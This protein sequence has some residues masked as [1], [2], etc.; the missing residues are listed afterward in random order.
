MLFCVFGCL[1]RH[2]IKQI[3]DLMFSA[4]FLNSNFLP[5]CHVSNCMLSPN[6]FRRMFCPKFK[7]DN[8]KYAY[9][10]HLLT[11]NYMIRCNLLYQHKFKSSCALLQI[12][13]VLG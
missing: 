6:I 3:G 4:S 9:F 8:L 12:M 1:K 10:H 5:V 7:I 11:W 2:I 13:Q